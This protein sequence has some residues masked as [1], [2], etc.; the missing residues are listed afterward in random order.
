MTHAGAE[1]LRSYLVEH[2]RPGLSVTGLATLAALVRD[3]AGALETEGRPVKYVH[4]TIVPA[5]EALLSV[6]ES[7][8]DELVH[9]VYTRADVQFDRMGEVISEGGPAWLAVDGSE[10][11]EAGGPEQSLGVSFEGG[12]HDS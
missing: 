1:R 6:F 8:T 12:N 3:A 5:D 9:E 11:V 7:A 2:Y 10:V 4:S